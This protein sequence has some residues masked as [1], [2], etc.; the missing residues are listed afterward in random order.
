M[1][2]VGGSVY[3]RQD[4]VSA[5]E[6]TCNP[7]DRQYWQRIEMSHEYPDD[8]VNALA[9]AGWLSILVPEEFG[10]GGGTLTDASVVLQTI[11]RSGGSSM[12]V[13]AQMYTMGTVLRHGSEEQKQWLLP[14]IARNEVRLQAFG[15]SE[16]DAGSETTAISTFARRTD[17]GYVING[18]KVWTSR[19]RHSDYLLLLA[20][21]TRLADVSRKTDGM[22]V[23]LVDLREAGDRITSQPIATMTTHTTYEIKIEN[24]EVPES[25]LIGEEGQG[26]KYLLSGL[27]AERILV[28]SESIGDGYW[29]LERAAEYANERI[30]FGSPIGKNQGVA[31]PLAS[32]YARVMAAEAI[33]DRA[34]AAFDSGSQPG[35]EANTAKLLASEAA[36]EAANACMDTF[37]GYG[38]AIEMGIEAKFRD[39]RLPLIAPVNNNLIKAF[40]AEKALGLPRSY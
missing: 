6:N 30:V 20:R 2:S 13:H 4:I 29:F 21:T 17:S 24:L 39:A 18:Q 16:P 9:K 7:F 34:A 33:R 14:L 25:A 5:V 38:L 28:A 35:L 32:A 15:I 27:N 37:G 23:F 11:N 26:F 36:W 1:N 40:I 3:E 22:A 31:F 10:G 8:F 19:F 12:H